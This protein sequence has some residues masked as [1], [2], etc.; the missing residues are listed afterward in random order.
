MTTYTADRQALLVMDVQP[1]IVDRIKNIETYLA[2]VKEAVD[3]AH[4]MNIPV[5]LVVVGFREGTPEIHASNKMFSSI[6]DGTRLGF[7]N[8]H[9]S[10][11]PTA[12]D[13]VITKR[14]VSAFSGSDLEVLLRAKN[15]DHLI[16][17]GI[18]TGGVVLSTLREAAD[19]DYRVTVLSD[20]CADVDDEVHSVLV[21][22]VFPRQATVMT[23]EEWS[24][25]L[26][27]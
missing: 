27:V 14:R 1:G 8:P 25:Q 9:P 11:S 23:S 22:K 7:I 18:A 26:L 19:K 15:I 6:K 3:R 12:D 21:H 13:I 24:K 17:A 2:K 5:F 16:L 10:L 20:L 4:Q